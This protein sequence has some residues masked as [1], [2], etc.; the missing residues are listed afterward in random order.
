MENGAA[1]LENSLAVSQRLSTE[2]PRD[3]GNQL[4]GLQN[5]RE[6]YVHTEICPWMFTAAA[7]RIAKK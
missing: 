2:L 5:Q 1:T 3:P 7:T 4:L 6:T